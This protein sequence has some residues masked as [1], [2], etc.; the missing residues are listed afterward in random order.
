MTDT[1]RTLV[2]LKPDAVERH[3]IGEIISRYEA[4]GLIVRAMELRTI[5]VDTA[6]NHYAEH[7]GRD[8]YPPLEEF[9]TSGPLV[10]LVLEGRKAIQVVRAMNGKTDCAEAAPGTIRGDYGTLKN[11]NLVHASDCPESAEREIGI[12]FPDL[13]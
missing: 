1:E 12:W 7:V 13:V 3:L 11:R 6:S 10:A 8:Y 9:I 5:D 2:L 4:K